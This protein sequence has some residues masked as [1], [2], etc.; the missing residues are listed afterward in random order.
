MDTSTPYQNNGS[1][2][3]YELDSAPVEELSFK[4][5][6]IE[7]EHIVSALE[8]GSLELEA[9][10]EYYRRGVELLS[11]LRERLA[12][13]EQQVQVLYDASASNQG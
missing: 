4:Q 5:A 13:A 11:S 12:A 1:G 7:L 6:S 10:L 8:N 2:D 3:V 9:A